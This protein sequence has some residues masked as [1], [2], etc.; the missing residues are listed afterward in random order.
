M[1]EIDLSPL[2]TVL[3]KLS[4][5]DR[6]ALL[7]ALQEAQI[8]YGY[9]PEPVAV[10]IGRSLHVPLADIYGVL[11]FYSMLY[12]QPTGEHILRV[13][14][15]PTCAIAGGEELLTSACQHLNISPGGTSV[16]GKFSV[17]RSPCLGLCDHAPAVLFDENPLGPVDTARPEQ[18][19]EGKGAR[20]TGVVDGSLH[21][22]TANCRNGVPTQLPDYEAQG[23]YEGLKTALQN[24]PEQAIV[25][26]KSA[27]L[28]GRGGAAFPTGIKWESAAAAPGETK[29]VVCNADESEPGTFKDRVLLEGDP[30]LVLEG[31]II[32]AY[33]TGAHKGYIYVR[34]EY[35]YIYQIASHAVR[36][37]R[38]AGYLGEN[39]LGSGFDFDI[40]LRLG[41]G[42]YICGEET[43]LFESI[44]GKRGFPR[45]KPPF[46]TTHGLFNQ[47]TVVSNVETLCNVPFILKNGSEAYRRMGTE[48][49]PG[50]KLF[51]L[52]GDVLQPGV[53]ELPFGVPLHELIF[54]LGGGIPNGR[55][56]QAVLLG[57]AAGCFAGPDQLDVPLSFEG[58]KSAG[59]LLGSGVVMVFDDTRD[60]RQVLVQLGRFFAHESCGKCYPCQ[61]GTQRQYEILKRIA[62]GK[63]LPEDAERLA[64]VGWTMTDSSLCGLGQTA[65]TAVL[66]AQELWP[67]LFR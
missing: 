41:A 34:G 51:C 65:A 14:T 55:S 5:Q 45:L 54:D 66:S 16:D 26:V 59:L 60:L 27:G 36:D 52:S 22:L 8:V 50:P 46:P 63:A 48:D 64:D 42:A 35:P 31:M 9:I 56:L 17:E 6:N 32:T 4:S 18:I 62:A 21:I 43:A 23:G 3:T 38:K 30:H 24:L 7:P 11:D 33:A 15:D 44:E 20:T 29:Y 61:L 28:V 39:I 19:L 25:Q 13:C 53:Y 40:E 49:S 2:Q 10:E 47:P 57:G 1:S 12:H 58:L 37:A 67:D